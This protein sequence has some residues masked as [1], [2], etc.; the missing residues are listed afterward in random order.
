MTFVKYEKVSISD[1]E[2]AAFVKMDRYLKNIAEYATDPTLK[3]EAGDLVKRLN[4]FFSRNI[5]CET[6][7]RVFPN[8]E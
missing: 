2:F 6:A 5:I 1:T 8:A 4:S 7:G 3:K